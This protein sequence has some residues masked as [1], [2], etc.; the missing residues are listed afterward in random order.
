MTYSHLARDELKILKVYFHHQTPV[1][2]IVARLKWS[3]QPVYNVINFLK[4]G[5]TSLDF[6]TKY[7]KR[8]AVNEQ[9]LSCRKNNS[10][11]FKTKLL[12]A[13]RWIS[14]LTTR[15]TVVG[16]SMRVY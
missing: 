12:E 1:M 11:T 13:G 15:G 3:K 16:Y 14:S 9:S 4:L 10:P 8:N 6:Y 7:K 5:Y 2:T